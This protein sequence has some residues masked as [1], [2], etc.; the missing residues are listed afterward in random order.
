MRAAVMYET[1]QPLVVDEIDV[2][3]PRND[4]VLVRIAA[5][6]V[7]RSDLHAL[8]GES[9]VAQPPMVL[10][11]EGAGLVEE[12]GPGVTGLAKGD[13]V[14]AILLRKGFRVHSQRG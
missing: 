4:E 5:S 2:A 11:H 7:C 8:D 10:G 14:V 9:P 3:S 6:G 12:V 13:A 1:H